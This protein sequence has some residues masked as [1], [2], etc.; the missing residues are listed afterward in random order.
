M[1]VKK[2][3]CVKKDKKYFTYQIAES[4]RP[5]KGKNPR[6]RILATITHLPLPLIEQISLL[7]K[8][9]EAQ[10]VFDLSQFFKSSFILGPILFFSLFMERVGIG[11]ALHLIPPKS[12]MLLWAV[13]LNRI[14]DPRSKLGSVTWVKRTAFPFLGGIEKETLMVNE[15]Y[16]AMDALYDRMEEVFDRFGKKNQKQTTL[17]L[18]DLTSIFFEGKGPQGL[19]QYGYS[20][21]HRED[22]PQILL[23]LCLNEKKLPVYFEVLAGNLQ[24]KK[25][26]IPFI[27][28]L[29]ERFHLTPA[30]FIGD[31]GMI[32]AENLQFLEKENL[33]YIIAL[34]HRE[35][36]E[37]IFSKN[38][39]PE[40]FDERI[41]VTIYEDNGEEVKKKKYVLCGSKYRKEHDVALFHLLLQKGRASLEKVRKMV[42]EGRLKDPVKVI[43]RAEKHLTIS[44]AEKFYDFRY[45]DGTFEIIEK[46][47]DIDKAHALCGYYILK[48]TASDLK[49]EEVERHYKGLK[50]VEDSFRELKDL[51]EV[52]PI[53]HWKE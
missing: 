53:F 34:T 16:Q 52:R 47:T 33:D 22:N 7:L 46:T 28:K 5:G 42:E 6:T 27:Q 2:S 10:V 45:E 21:D 44:G 40:L 18:Y 36:R 23:S 35:A 29:K 43:R 19:A 41:P 12:R 8:S 11:E 20:R 13:I 31:R 24:D 26:V 9:P 30:I 37:L 49:D 14:L 50:W 4:Y 38:I 39:Q 25:T 1:F 51:V 17:L 48:T 3:W 32:T 15:I